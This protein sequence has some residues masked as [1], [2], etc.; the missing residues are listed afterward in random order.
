[1]GNIV[2]STISNILGAFSLG[3]L[4]HRGSDEILFDKSS[5]IYSLVV[6]FLTIFVAGLTGFGHNSMW[7]ILGGVMIGLFVIYVTSI[8]WTISKGRI[9][10]P[11]LSDSDSSDE[12][13]EEN[14][15]Q[16]SNRSIER[17][18]SSARRMAN[19]AIERAGRDSA[20]S[21][22]NTAAERQ[23]ATVVEA[24]SS[25]RA[26][27]SPEIPRA[28]STSPSPQADSSRSSNHSLPYHISLLVVGFLALVL[29]SY[30]L[31]HAASNLVDQ[32]GISDVL[33]GVV[34]LSIATTIPEK[35]VAVISGFRGH[36]GIMVANT[37][38]S[39]IFLL[40]LCMGILWVST[41]GD[42]DQGSVNATELGVM[43]GSTVAMTLTVWFGSRWI[44]WIGSVMLVAY[45]AFLVLEFTVIRRTWSD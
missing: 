10:A 33:F 36:A 5:K 37:V 6:L 29:S 45:V 43:L 22:N 41:G 38:G 9:T 16:Q 8:A 15:G 25:E 19:G 4:F 44:R 12:E 17:A 26:T 20:S 13:S 35:F 11:E 42:F 40:S 1:M 18:T 32:L 34:I 21:A 7:R 39:N 30:V 3:L 14:T 31:S 28:S 2:G 27:H 23:P 24:D